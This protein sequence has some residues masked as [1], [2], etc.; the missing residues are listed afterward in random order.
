MSLSTETYSTTQQFFTLLPCFTVRVTK[1]KNMMLVNGVNME[2]TEALRRAL[3]AV[4]EADV[5]DD[6]RDKAFEKAFDW[7]T[8]ES[9]GP[10]V[11]SNIQR[12]LEVRTP[13]IGPL[14][15][16][17]NKLGLDP[18]VIEDV[19]YEE[20]GEIGI[21]IAASRLDRSKSGGTRQLALLVAAARQGSGQEEWTSSPEI[22]RVCADYG[23]FDS[24]NFATTIRSMGTV[25]SYRGKGHSLEIRLTRPGMEQASAL[26]GELANEG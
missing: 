10:A 6:L 17:A 13:S 24:A 26:V 16:L 2:L 15:Q 1:P 3:S 18:A 22:R 5:P 19:F 4:E 21:G 9:G 8:R 11:S 7:L 20:D 12:D 23:R 14:R 25:F